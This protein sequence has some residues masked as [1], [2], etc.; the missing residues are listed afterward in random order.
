MALDFAK[1]YAMTWYNFLMSSM[2]SSPSLLPRY[3][4]DS[5]SNNICF[6]DVCWPN[7][8]NKG[9]SF[10]DCIGKKLYAEVAFG[11]TSTHSSPF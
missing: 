10:D 8:R 6:T 9:A 7:I 2:F 3:F 11:I 4:G 1:L 5:E